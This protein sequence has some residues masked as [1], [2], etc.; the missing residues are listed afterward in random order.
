MPIDNRDVMRG[1]FGRDATPF[2]RMMEP[3]GQAIDQVEAQ[4]RRAHEMN[5]ERLRQKVQAAGSRCSCAVAMLSERRVPLGIYAASGR[6]IQPNL[7][8]NLNAE[9]KTALHSLRCQISFGR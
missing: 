2:L 8:K 1:L 5:Q 9:L 7:F 6:F 4:R 3:L